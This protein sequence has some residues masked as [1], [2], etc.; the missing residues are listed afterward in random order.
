MDQKT[1]NARESAPDIA[2]SPLAAM[3]GATPFAV[4]L[5]DTEPKVIAVSDAW[6]VLFDLTDTNETAQSP[7]SAAPAI[8][9]RELQQLLK[10]L[11][12]GKT[13]PKLIEIAATETRHPA[14]VRLEAAPWIGEDAKPGGYLISAYSVTDMVEAH[15]ETETAL[16]RARD[17]SEAANTAKSE[18]LAN[19]SHEIRTPMNG[20]IGM[21]GLLLRT[22]LTVEQR[23][24]AEAVRVSADCLL[25]L[26]NDILD[27]SK[28]EAGKVELERIDFSLGSMVEDVVELLSPKAVEKGLEIV[29]FIDEGAR[30]D[31]SGDPTRLRQVVLNLLSNALKF[32][33][34]GFVAVEVRTESSD[35]QR[36]RLR[37]E[38]QD[39]G[40]GLSAEAK[41]KLFTKFQQADG[42][43][44][45][46]YGGTGLGLSICRQL[47][48]LMGGR[49]GVSDRD[50]GGSVFWIEVELPHAANSVN[51]VV[52]ERGERDLAG[53][54]ILVVDDMEI[55][56]IIFQRQLEMEGAIVS[57]AADGPAALA[58]LVIAD[59]RGEP[60]DIVLL[61]HMMP[62]LSGEGVAAKIRANTALFQPK[63]VLASSIGEMVGAGGGANGLFDAVFTK[64][65]R[66]SVLINRLAQLAVGAAPIVAAPPA[67]AT[68]SD[69]DPAAP[70]LSVDDF[71]YDEPSPMPQGR[72]RILLAEDNEINTL[73]ATTILQ[74]SGYTI[75]CVVNGEEAVEAVRQ[76]TFDLILMDMQMPRM[77]GLQATRMIRDLPPPA[78][79][80]PIIAM[81]AN[82]MRKDQ[83]ACIAAGMNDFVSKPID[84]EAF[85][86]VVA[87]FMGAELW[88]DE[89]LVAPAAAAKKVAD[90]DPAKL[91]GLARL[92]P[93]DRM[94]KVVESYLAAATERL[95]RI[96]S[97]MRTEDFAS[98][99]REA[100]DLK[101]TSGNFGALRLQAMAE[102]L[103][104]AC[105]AQDDA[106]APR[107]VGE[108]R[109][110]SV[111]A[112]GLIRDWLSEFDAEPQR[113][114]G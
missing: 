50:G 58:S 43:V 84:P 59:A 37:M 21:N 56:R 109:Q 18:F 91:T 19:M 111:I 99:A 46:K 81:T 107:L 110:G 92:L 51:Q 4:A 80:T 8:A 9:E 60:F 40:I 76:Q 69:T 10:A 63:L 28:L 44:T 90:V 87:R 94:R 72:G 17:E 98:V 7:A 68:P 88:D 79:T 100:H 66:Q 16:T 103:E 11:K 25:N 78:G 49:I 83:D 67:A 6:R 53:K 104:R 29:A 38:I 15:R 13:G 89:P 42:S 73:L 114:L 24:Y 48:E 108:I 106:E 71:F 35:R 57:E 75:H 101:G 45:R 26:I 86:Q 113:A 22:D 47:V 1:A 55:N 70:G 12:D 34:H 112:W 3:V 97:L 65:V 31:F 2:S 14:W 74:E 61:D 30:R 5:I 85:L 41:T 95:V 64:P 20:V 23:K 27:I 32:T 102:Q 54:R 93:P 33:E 96:E 105:L 39:T 62:G 36:A 52:P 77:D 82:A